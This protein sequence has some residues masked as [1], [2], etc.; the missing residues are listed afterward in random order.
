MR[1][2]PLLLLLALALA[3]PAQAAEVKR[4][5]PA[6]ERVLLPSLL[7]SRL[8]ALH[9]GPVKPIIRFRA[10]F[11]L[12]GAGDYKV[13]VSSFGDAVI[14]EVWK[15]RKGRRTSTAYLARGVAAQGRLQA[16]FGKF[17][18]VSM[19]FRQSRNRTWFGKRRSCKGASRFVKRRGVFV[20]NLRFRGEDGYV[21]VRAQRAKGAV[22]TEAAKCQRRRPPMSLPD[23]DFLFFQP[24]TALL[25]LSRDGVDATALMAMEGRKRTLFL[26]TDEEAR[27]KLA[28]VRTALARAP[29]PVQVNEA[30]TRASLAPPPPFHGSARY[31]AFP[32]GTTTWTGNLSVNLPGAPRFPLTG[33]GYETLLE[34]PF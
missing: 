10:G 31:R 26:A 21:A 32:D 18:R 2:L 24:K 11:V 19:R 7:T 6:T 30:I 9:G 3:A 12:E 16:T 25:A 8:L 17:G 23:L 27:G 22:I 14:L 5:Q 29:S 28:I 4:A 33:P 34:V 13:G 1:R 15:G 20:G